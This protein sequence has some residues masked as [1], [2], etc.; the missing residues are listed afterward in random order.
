MEKWILLY[1]VFGALFIVGAFKQTRK[2]V[3]PFSAFCIIFLGMFIWPYFIYFGV[4]QYI[5]QQRRHRKLKTLLSKG[6]NG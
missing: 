1:L 6:K 5:K 2:A 3:S 4:C